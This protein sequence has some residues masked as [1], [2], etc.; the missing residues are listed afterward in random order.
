M[1]NPIPL[2]PT[3]AVCLEALRSGADRKTVIALRENLN[4]RQT[5]LALGRLASLGLA[6]TESGRAWNLTPKGKKASTR[7]VCVVRA[8]GRKRM[9]EPSPGSSAARLMALLD[10]PRRAAD[11]TRFLGVTRQ[12]VHQMVV[13]LSA[14]GLIRCADPSF[15]TFAIARKDDLST[16]LRRDEERVLSAFPEIYP[17]TLSKIAAV[18]KMCASKIATLAEALSLVS[19]IEKTGTTD[20]DLYQLTATGLAHWQRSA[21]A[22]HAN[23]PPPPFRSDRVHNVLTHLVSHG[24]TRTR[25]VGLKLEIP[26]ISMNALMQ[27][28]KR[29]NAVR[30]QTDARFAPYTLTPTGHEMLAAMNRARM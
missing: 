30:T 18:T 24:P 3:E 8:G 19:L 16:L 23:S 6:T 28:L 5:K 12:R 22:R 1:K 17:T 25:D 2:S 13:N 4:L 7:I 21:T 29:K 9:T 26:P 14:L 11:L 27:Y 20:G 10:R 15:P